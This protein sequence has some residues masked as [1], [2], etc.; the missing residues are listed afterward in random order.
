M[1]MEMATATEEEDTNDDGDYTNDDCNVNGIPNYLDP[2]SCDIV[3]N[4]FSPNNDGDNDN[5]YYS[6]IRWIPKL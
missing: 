4:G 2:L 6:A 1:M 5:I 3:P